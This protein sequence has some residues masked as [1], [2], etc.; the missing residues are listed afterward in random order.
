MDA[1]LVDS[2]KAAL[3][4]ETAEL[5]AHGPGA[6]P[7]LVMIRDRDLRWL[8]PLLPRLQAYKVVHSAS[9]GSRAVVLLANDQAALLLSQ[10]NS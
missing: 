8:L 4:R 2:F 9:V 1:A 5:D 10:L 3:D 7:A 6:A